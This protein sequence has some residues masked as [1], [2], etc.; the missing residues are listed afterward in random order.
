ME[1]FTALLGVV[2]GFVLSEG[3]KVFWSSRTNKTNFKAIRAEIEFCKEIAEVYLSQNIMAPLYRMPT[4]AYEAS[5]PQLLSSSAIEEEEL[6]AVQKFYM[7][8]ESFNRGLDQAE[9]ARNDDAKLKAEYKR[10]QGKAS[11]LTNTANNE[12]NYYNEVGR[13]LTI[14][15]S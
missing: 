5:L 12:K 11:Y 14:R 15:C 3:S 8:V 7:E 13:L 9:L 1:I 10:N 4:K 2:V 6:K